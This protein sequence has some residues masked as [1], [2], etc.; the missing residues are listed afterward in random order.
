MSPRSVDELHH[1]GLVTLYKLLLPIDTIYSHYLLS[2]SLGFSAVPFTF[3]YLLMLNDVGVDGA[4][5]GWFQSEFIEKWGSLRWLWTGL[6]LNVRSC[7]SFNRLRA[8]Y[9]IAF[10]G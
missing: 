3:M 10:Q 4:K 8:D 7:Y 2:A 5:R 9:P 1:L 6:F